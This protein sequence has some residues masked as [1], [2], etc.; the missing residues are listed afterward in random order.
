MDFIIIIVSTKISNNS[1]QNRKTL[2][3]FSLVL[4]YA[5]PEVIFQNV[6]KALPSKKF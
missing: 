6:L 1:K 3:Y 4:F 2:I 5:Q